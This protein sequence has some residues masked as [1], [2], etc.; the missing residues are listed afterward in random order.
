MS[1]LLTTP[2]ALPQ[3]LS[4][5]F[6]PNLH[7]QIDALLSSPKSKATPKIL[8]AWRLHQ[9]DFRGAAA[10]LLSPLQAAQAKVKRGV[11]GLEDDFLAVIN[12]LACAGKDD[13]W[14]LGAGGDGK[15]GGGGGKGK[16]RVVTVG[17]VRGLYQKELDRKSVIESGRFG[18]GGGM[19]GVD[20][21]DVL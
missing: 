19:D 7:A 9:N 18:F 4:L 5:P 11:D 2:N 3:L 21:M 1:A 15:A 8:A 12:F 14:V 16:R 13:G 17:D 6:P 20:E 10:A